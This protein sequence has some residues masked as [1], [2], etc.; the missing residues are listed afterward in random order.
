MALQAGLVRANSRVRGSS[1]YQRQSRALTVHIGAGTTARARETFMPK[2]KRQQLQQPKTPGVIPLTGGPLHSRTTGSARP[3]TST[4]E[5]QTPPHGSLRRGGPD[6]QGRSLAS[7]A[8]EI[9]PT[10]EGA[11]DMIV[12][13]ASTADREATSV[14]PVDARSPPTC[15]LRRT[16]AGFLPKG[17]R[18]IGPSRSVDRKAT[19]GLSDRTT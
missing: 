17:R 14:G 18:L 10:Y 3:Y 6:E 5:V 12:D 19:T 8:R 4:C 11:K 9:Q 1:L 13:R 16:F 2:G 7:P 15:W